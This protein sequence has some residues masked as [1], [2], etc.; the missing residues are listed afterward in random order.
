M[1]LSKPENAALEKIDKTA[2]GTD[3][4]SDLLHM[5]IDYFIDK[6]TGQR[7]LM[8]EL[9]A[10]R[11]LLLRDEIN[12]KQ[13]LTKP[14]ILA[15]YKN[16]I[17]GILPDVPED[18]KSQI[19]FCWVL[20]ECGTLLWRPVNT[21]HDRPH[22]SFLKNQ[23]HQYMAVNGTNS[24]TNNSVKQSYYLKTDEEMYCVCHGTREDSFLVS[25][26]FVPM[27]RAYAGT[28]KLANLWCDSFFNRKAYKNPIS[29]EL[30]QTYLLCII[31]QK[32]RIQDS[33]TGKVICTSED[34]T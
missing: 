12:P 30:I 25:I 29:E 19:D 24:A 26:I 13:D 6:K 32:C 27:L 16:A 17:R 9:D 4:A 28:S 15:K 18:M 34:S 23:A 10:P 1:S 22:A 21:K 2:P 7:V 8:A 14:T 31:G 20:Y 3:T 11:L 5:P 33:S